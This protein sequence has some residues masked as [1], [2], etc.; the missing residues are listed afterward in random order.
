MDFRGSTVS[1]KKIR[2]LYDFHWP[3]NVRELEHVVDRL[4][5][6]HGSDTDPLKFVLPGPSQESD[7]P[8][9]ETETDITQTDLLPVPEESLYPPLKDIEERHIRRTL[10][11]CSVRTGQRRFWVSTTAHCAQK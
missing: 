3:G 8:S 4:L 2:R 10:E 1:E 6:M 7:L 11:K 9:S 5:I